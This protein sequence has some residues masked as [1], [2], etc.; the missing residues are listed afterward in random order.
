MWAAVTKMSNI[1]DRDFVGH[2]EEEKR[3]LETRKVKYYM[4]AKYFVTF[5]FETVW[6]AVDV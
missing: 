2:Q 3:L 1:C 5:L 4:V 6:K